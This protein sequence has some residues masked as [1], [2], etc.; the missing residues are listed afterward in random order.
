M[1]TVEYRIH[2]TRPQDGPM[3]GVSNGTVFVPFSGREFAEYVANDERDNLD[4]YITWPL[5]DTTLAEEPA[6]EIR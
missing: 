6:D 1:K 5:E 2:K 3:W 4:I